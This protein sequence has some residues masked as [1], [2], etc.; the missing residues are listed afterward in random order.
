MDKQ[1][2][3]E[4]K[5]LK[6]KEKA[7]AKRYKKINNGLDLCLIASCFLAFLAAAVVDIIKEKRMESRDE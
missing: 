2:K 7:R 3:K 5:L 6:K 4:K 1:V